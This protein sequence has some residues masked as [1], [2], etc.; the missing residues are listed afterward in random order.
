MTEDLNTELIITKNGRFFIVPKDTIIGKSL[1]Y[2]GEYAEHEMMLLSR[3]VQSEDTVIDVGANIGTHAVFFSHQV[4][5]AGSVLAFEAQPQLFQLLKKNLS[6][7][8]CQNVQAHNAIVGNGTAEMTTMI[9]DYNRDG[10]FGAFSFRINNL[11]HYLP[12]DDS[13]GELTLPGT[14]LDDWAVKNCHLLKVDSE[15]MET[16]ILAGAVNM[17]GK[18]RP[19]LYLENN[20]R[21]SSPALIEQIVSLDYCA[22]WHVISY[23]RPDN[24]RKFPEN[25]FSA[26]LELNLFCVPKEIDVDVP[27]LPLVSGPAH[28]MPDDIADQKFNVDDLLLV[29]ETFGR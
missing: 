13:R 19:F 11:E 1:K 16:E 12:M 28:W 3:W 26:P 5:P 21:A 27:G 18:H 8:G 29:A 10:N 17:I 15:G 25:I 22:H 14:N 7:N 4:G 2:Y 9:P 6:E 23:Y 20:N 24:Y